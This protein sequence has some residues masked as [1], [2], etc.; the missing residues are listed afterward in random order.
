MFSVG[1]TLSSLAVLILVFVVIRD[2]KG[3]EN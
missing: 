1:I 2:R 3:L